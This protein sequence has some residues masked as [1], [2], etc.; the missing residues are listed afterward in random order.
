MITRRSSDTRH[1]RPAKL[2]LR[3]GRFNISVRPGGCPPLHCPGNFVR[4]PRPLAGGFCVTLDERISNGR[5][6]VGSMLGSRVYP[7][8]VR[9]KNL[10]IRQPGWVSGEG[11]KPS[12]D[13]PKPVPNFSGRMRPMF[14][15]FALV[16]CHFRP[17]TGLEACCRQ[18]A[19]NAPPLS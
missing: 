16:F 4:H 19:P 17:Q 9:R 6:R 2:Q 8:L 18:G 14:G 13:G 10:H 11:R 1:L 5:N 12:A 7:G 15:P 3:K